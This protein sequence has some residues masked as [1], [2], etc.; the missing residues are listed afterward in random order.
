MRSLLALIAALVVGTFAVR[1]A[2]YIDRPRP[3]SFV[4]VLVAGLGAR[5]WRP[6]PPR[7]G[8]A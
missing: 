3:V 7:L 5:L 2:P 8:T 4:V 6:A 1:P